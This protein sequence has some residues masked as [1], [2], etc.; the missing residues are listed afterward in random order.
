VTTTLYEVSK[1]DQSKAASA[2]A[3][4]RKDVMDE[5]VMLLGRRAKRR[6]QAITFIAAGSLVFGLV[7]FILYVMTE[8]GQIMQT[9][10]S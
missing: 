5:V 1:R 9:M 7:M 10:F 3:K 6:Q 4:L 2:L 8:G